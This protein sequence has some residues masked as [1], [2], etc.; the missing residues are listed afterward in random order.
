M[1]D[2]DGHADE[3]QRRKFQVIKMSE[4]PITPERRVEEPSDDGHIHGTRVATCE[5]KLHGM[6]KRR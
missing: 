3:E 6:E 2:T 4:G 1:P 5:L